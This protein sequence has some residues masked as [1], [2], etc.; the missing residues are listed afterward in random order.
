MKEREKGWVILGVGVVLG[1]RRG[2]ERRRLGRGVGAP[3]NIA[4]SRTE[5]LDLRADTRA[6]AQ[7]VELRAR[8]L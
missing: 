3:R 6:V 7:N 1:Y 5:R 4:R 2:C 8:Q